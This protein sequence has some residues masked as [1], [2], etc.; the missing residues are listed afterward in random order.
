LHSTQTLE[1]TFDFSIS[2]EKKWSFMSVRT[3]HVRTRQT[4][5]HENHAFKSGTFWPGRQL[6]STQKP[7]ERQSHEPRKIRVFAACIQGIAPKNRLHFFYKLDKKRASNECETTYAHRKAK[8]HQNRVLKKH[9][10]GSAPGSRVYEKPCER[11]P[12]AQAG[13]IRFSR[14]VSN[15]I[16]PLFLL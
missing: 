8:F 7:R 1:L 14:H 6:K 3:Q 16:S 2:G 5:L 12:R 11:A 10:P 9:L 13:K 15:K 4:Y